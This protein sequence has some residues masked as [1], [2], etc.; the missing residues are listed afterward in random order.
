MFLG[1][2]LCIIGHFIEVMMLCQPV[3][4]IPGVF[5]QIPLAQVLLALIAFF[6]TI[7]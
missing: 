1:H 6:H 3:P 5:L 4:S 7:L 2:Y